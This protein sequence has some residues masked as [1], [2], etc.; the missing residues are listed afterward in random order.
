[1]SSLSTKKLS[2]TNSPTQ[3]RAN[4][5]TPYSRDYGAIPEDAKEEEYKLGTPVYPSLVYQTASSCQVLDEES[6]SS[7]TSLFSICTDP[8]TRRFSILTCLNST[9]IALLC[10]A[11]ALRF[12]GYNNP[13]VCFGILFVFSAML[14]M[15]CCCK[16]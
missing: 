4:S 10:S 15:I 3:S 13:A 6:H 14:S 9:T 12:F 16:K 7:T 2:R 5:P 11:L 1:M 8:Q